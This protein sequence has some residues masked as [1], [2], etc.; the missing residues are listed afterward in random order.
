VTGLTWSYLFV[1]RSAVVTC[2]WLFLVAAARNAL[3]GLLPG[4]NPLNGPLSRRGFV[5]RAVSPSNFG[6]APPASPPGSL[7]DRLRTVAYSARTL[8]FPP[9]SN[10]GLHVLHAQG[11]RLFAFFSLACWWLVP[12][13]RKPR[14][15]VPLP[16][17]RLCSTPGTFFPGLHTLPT[18][19]RVPFIDIVSSFGPLFPPNT[20]QS[21]FLIPRT[22]ARVS[23]SRFL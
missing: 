9:I 11:P 23:P 7:A 5:S 16:H 18:L 12:G 6:T 13:A 20:S 8:F 14:L 10:V 19:T 15:Q 22:N 3:R 1:E 4:T 2:L 21:Q 17:Q